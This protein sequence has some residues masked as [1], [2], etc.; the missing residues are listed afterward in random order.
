MA[1]LALLALL[2]FLVRLAAS[3]CNARARRE[4]VLTE[5]MAGPGTGDLA[6]VVAAV[7]VVIAAVRAELPDDVRFKTPR[8]RTCPRFMLCVCGTRCCC[9]L[10]FGMLVPA[11]AAPPCPL[12]FLAPGCPKDVRRRLDMAALLPLPASIWS[13]AL[14][15][16][17]DDDAMVACLFLGTRSD[18]K[19]P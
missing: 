13:M 12:L 19:Y 1:R 10:D 18:G 15:L 2:L 4:P 11:L 9:C 7:V 8:P 5:T 14:P 3:C 17:D 16:D 6:R